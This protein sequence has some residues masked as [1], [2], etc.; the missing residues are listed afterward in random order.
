MFT[1]LLH[2]LTTEHRTKLAER[3]IGSERL[4][5]WNRAEFWQVVIARNPRIAPGS[6]RFID[7][8]LDTVLNGPA[9]TALD[10]TSRDLI[11]RREA[12]QKRSQARLR[13]LRGL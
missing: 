13:A 10:T 9:D 5:E 8:W 7:D 1:E 6:R 11:A 12:T 4:T 2:A 3:G